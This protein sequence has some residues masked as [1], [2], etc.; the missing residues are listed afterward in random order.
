MRKSATLLLAQITLRATLRDRVLHMLLG[1]GFF[2]LLLVPA[3]SLF[4]MRQVQELA[5]TLVLSIIS[6]F[7]LVSA[8]LLGTSS[9]WRD[10]ECHSTAS[11]LGLPI[12]RTAYVLGKFF[13]TAFFLSLSS[14]FLG[15]VS[16]AVMALAAAQYPAQQPI[17]WGTFAYAVFFYSCKYI[18]LAAVALLFSAIS[19]S[20][21]LPVFGTIAIFM[22]GSAS[23]EVMAYLSSDK[24]VQLSAVSKS[25][26]KA[27]YYILPNFSAFD[28][29]VYAIYS[30]PLPLFGL[31]YTFAYFL[32]YTAIILLLA[33]WSFAKRELT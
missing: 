23:Q 33:A 10:I 1:A 4:S 26:T 22:A 8:V 20:F 9:I 6:L 11:V 14:F 5:I 24:V 25:V 30:L 12:S 7:L 27:L 32:V 18:L 3:F 21:F 16:S 2:I 28:L 31:A 29:N 13:G 15:M 17:L 19:T